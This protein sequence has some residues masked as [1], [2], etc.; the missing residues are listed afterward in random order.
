MGNL[1]LLGGLRE[2]ESFL[3]SSNVL[4]NNSHIFPS[5]QALIPGN[6]EISTNNVLSSSSLHVAI[7]LSKEVKL[8]FITRGTRVFFGKDSMPNI[9]C[10]S[11]GNVEEHC[12]LVS[13]SLDNDATPTDPKLD[14]VVVL[15]NDQVVVALNTNEDEPSYK[16]EDEFGI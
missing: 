14:E 7:I 8:D 5:I 13:Q 10:L 2:L 4:A 1:E 6:W 3:G 11:L 9:A 15:S 12:G 16:D